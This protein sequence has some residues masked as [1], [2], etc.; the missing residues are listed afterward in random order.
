MQNPARLKAAYPLRKGSGGPERNDGISFLHVGDFSRAS[1]TTTGALTA[2]WPGSGPA[3]GAGFGSRSSAD[4]ATQ[5]RQKPEGGVT[6]PPPARPPPRLVGGIFRHRLFRSQL[7]LKKPPTVRS[8]PAAEGSCPTAASRLLAGQRPD[9]GHPR[10]HFSARC[11]NTSGLPAGLTPSRF[12]KLF[13]FKQQN[14]INILEVILLSLL[15]LFLFLT[16]S[17]VESQ[18]HLFLRF[19]NFCEHL[20]EKKISTESLC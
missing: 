13:L 11:A 4:E 20:E 17:R 8:R 5:K 19:I 12:F 18:L 1:R 10:T 15:F 7:E 9:I 16:G 14:M 3:R 6:T 2:G